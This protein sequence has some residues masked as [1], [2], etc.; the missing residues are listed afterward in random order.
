MLYAFDFFPSKVFNYGTS[1]GEKLVK[2]IFVFVLNPSKYLF[3]SFVAVPYFS[4][5]IASLFTLSCTDAS[6]SISF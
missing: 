3:N 2:R 4:V 1:Y 5:R 6:S